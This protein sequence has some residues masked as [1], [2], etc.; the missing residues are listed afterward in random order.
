MN[1]L[2]TALV[3]LIVGSAILPVQITVTVLLL[4]SEVGRLPAVA[5]VA[6]MTVVRLA[7][8]IVFGFVIGTGVAEAEGPDRP[9]PIA[10]TLLLVVAVLFLVGAARKLLDEPDDD[11]P[12]PAWMAMMA[13]AT[14]SRALLFG[15]GV[16]ALSPKL[17]AFTLGAIGVIAEAGLG[18]SGAIA[19]FLVFVVA[20]E[21]IHLAL[22]A[23][24]DAAPGRAGP[25]L[26]RVSQALARYN[27]PLMIGL[28]VV[29]GIWFMVKALAGFGVL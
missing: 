7:Q 14:P 26:E 21:S 25:M 23:L 20:A 28:G 15:A 9:G 6:G 29:F 4:R 12:P 2:W 24:A 18:Q 17:W 11:A 22:V 19:T 1:D 8:G 13:S 3:P 5:W 10:S 27:R 16:V